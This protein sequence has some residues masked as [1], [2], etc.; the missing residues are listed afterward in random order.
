MVTREKMRRAAA[1][2][3]A[4]VWMNDPKKS[5]KF[6]DFMDEW[7][8]NH[9]TFTIEET[10]CTSEKFSDEERRAGLA[11]CLKYDTY[12]QSRLTRRYYGPCAVILPVGDRLQYIEIGVRGE[13]L[14]CVKD[15]FKD[16]ERILRIIGVK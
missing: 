8:L 16:N 1:M 9:P 3:A 7:S 10:G 12:V 2:V 14:S 5:K 6:T 13:P 11:W 4:D 15:R